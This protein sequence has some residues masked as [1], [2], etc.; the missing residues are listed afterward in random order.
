MLVVF[1]LKN[2]LKYGFVMMNYVNNYYNVLK[3]VVIGIYCLI[4]LE[5]EIY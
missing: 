1:F 3:F 4:C 5:Y 2:K